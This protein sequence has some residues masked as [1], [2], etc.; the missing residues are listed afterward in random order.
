MS[1]R[2]N[3]GVEHLSIWGG[4]CL[5]TELLTLVNT[6]PDRV[7][8]PYRIWEYTDHITIGKED[9]PE[10]YEWLER[11]RIFGVGGDLSIRRDG[12]GFRWWFIGLQGTEPPETFKKSGTPYFNGERKG[13]LFC[14]NTDNK[15]MLWGNREKDKAFWDDRV[16][17]ASIDYPVDEHATRA[18]IEYTTYSRA[19]QVVF[20]WMKKLL[21]EKKEA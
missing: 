4:T 21:P 13:D 9:E 7:K 10:G 3:I 5:E 11:G 20:V 17:G 16:A 18:F 2:T 1:T 14:E 15:A 8:M 19:G 12:E 6:W